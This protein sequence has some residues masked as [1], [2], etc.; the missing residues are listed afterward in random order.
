MDLERV[1][2]SQAHSANPKISKHNSLIA[3]AVAFNQ[4]FSTTVGVKI[5]LDECLESLPYS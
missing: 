5:T 3:G 1:S 2:I 4:A